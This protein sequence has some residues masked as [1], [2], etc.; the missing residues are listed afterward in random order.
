MDARIG[1]YYR[2]AVTMKENPIFKSLRSES[3]PRKS[4]SSV[5]NAAILHKFDISLSDFNYNANHAEDL[6][7]YSGPIWIE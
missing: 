7:H 3:Y 2:Y 6:M 4:P 5:Y 1:E